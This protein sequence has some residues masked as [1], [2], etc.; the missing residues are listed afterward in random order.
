MDG[1]MKPHKL[2][3][4]TLPK[5]SWNRRQFRKNVIY[6]K[7]NNDY[8]MIQ[9]SK[10]TATDPNY[11]GD[12]SLFNVKNGKWYIRW[13]NN[14]FQLMIEHES[15]KDKSQFL[16]NFND[17]N[18]NIHEKQYEILDKLKKEQEYLSNILGY[19]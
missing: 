2:I 5:L 13:D 8:F 17:W 6:S 4:D 10:M 12:V 7:H 16:Y 11:H 14:M 18:E 15:V 3:I 9:S 19:Y 1:E